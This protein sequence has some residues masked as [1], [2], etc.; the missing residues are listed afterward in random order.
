M[1]LR[2]KFRAVLQANI[3]SDKSS[4][5]IKIYQKIFNC[6]ILHYIIF[7]AAYTHAYLFLVVL[8]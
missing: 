1:L 8:S 6:D 4:F 7:I 2:K 3:S 5:F